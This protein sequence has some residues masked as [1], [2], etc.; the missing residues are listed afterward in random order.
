MFVQFVQRSTVVV[1]KV[2]AVSVRKLSAQTAIQNQLVENFLLALGVSA[3]TARIDSEGIE[4]HVSTE[5]LKAM[6]R[7][8]VRNPNK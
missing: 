5:T 6:A 4:H 7:Y 2:I 8:M 3:E 1:K